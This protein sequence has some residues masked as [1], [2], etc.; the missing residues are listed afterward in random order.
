[1]CL[2]QSVH[3]MDDVP[4]RLYESQEAA[5]ADRGNWRRADAGAASRFTL[6][7]NA[8]S[9]RGALPGGQMLSRSV[10]GVASSAEKSLTL[11]VQSDLRELR[12]YL[13]HIP[14]DHAAVG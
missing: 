5:L 4:V 13:G 6:K 9:E 7:I 12:S 8:V 3:T 10:R 1:M 11:P 2:L 14:D